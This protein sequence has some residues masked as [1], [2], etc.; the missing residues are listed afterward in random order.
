VRSFATR[1]DIDAPAQAV[2]DVLVDVASW[3]AWNGTVQRVVGEVAV[4]AR[5][6]VFVSQSPGRAFPVRITELESPRRMVWA[7]GMPFG[8]FKGIRVFE[9]SPLSADAS[10]FS[11]RERYEGLLTPL[12][13]RSIPDLQPSFD[14]FA[15]CLKRRAERG[16]GAR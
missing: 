13:G 10:A 11:M 14:E 12:I 1:V 6:T 9:V 4:G 7:G 15:Q 8:L 16:A 3:P 2:W 5:V